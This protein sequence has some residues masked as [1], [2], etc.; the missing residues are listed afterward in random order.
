MRLIAYLSALPD[1]TIA[2][3][4][5]ADDGSYQLSADARA[6]VA[7]MFGSRF[8]GSLAYQDSWAMIGRKGSPAPISEHLSTDSQVILDKVLTLPAP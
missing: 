6:A 7:T 4:A 8:I 5:I 1:G 3:F 2:L